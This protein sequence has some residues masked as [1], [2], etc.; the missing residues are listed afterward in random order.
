MGEAG[1]RAAVEFRVMVLFG[2]I[3]QLMDTRANKLFATL[4]LSRS[5]FS[6]L[7]HFSHNPE[8][9]WTVTALAQVMEMNQPGVTKVVKKLLEKGLLKTYPNEEDSRVKLL[10]IT[11][12]GL[13]YL[14]KASQ[15]FRP[16]VAAIFQNWSDQ[17]LQ[18][19]RT[20]LEKHKDW[21]DDNR[22]T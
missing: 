8:R 14:D 1:T 20:L 11:G 12:K 4:D 15:Q 3:Q 17:E 13:R 6:V 16:R 10:G 19:L 9:H 5:Q 2:I 7:L 18:Q 21:L 22:E